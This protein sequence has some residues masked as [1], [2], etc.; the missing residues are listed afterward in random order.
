MDLLAFN[1]IKRLYP[2]SNDSVCAP[3]DIEEELLSL[4]SNCTAC[5][6][7]WPLVGTIAVNAMFIV[8]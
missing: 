4:A 5:T 6:P 7:K 1:N 8:A 2:I 3:V